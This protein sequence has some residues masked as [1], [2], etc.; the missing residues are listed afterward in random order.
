MPPVVL[1]LSSARVHPSP[2]VFTHLNEEVFL[3]TFRSILFAAICVAVLLAPFASAQTQP[4][5]IITYQGNGQMVCSLCGQGAFYSRFEPIWAKVVDANGNPVPGTTVYWNVQIG[6][7]LLNN[8]VTVT[9]NNGLTSNYYGVYDINGSYGYPLAQSQIIASIGSPATSTATFYE[10]QALSLNDVDLVQAKATTM[11]TSLSGSAGTVVQNGIVGGAASLTGYPV[12]GVELLLIN[13]Q[14]S[15]S[16]TCA[17]MSGNA[18]V[19]DPGTV[20]TQSNGYAVCSPI[21]SGSGSGSFSIILGGVAYSPT[22]QGTVAYWQSSNIPLTVTAPSPGSIV[23]LFGN[24]QSAT[25]GQPLQAPLMATVEDIKGNP[26][27]GETV[28]WSVSP[29]GA[30]TF[31]NPSSVSDSNGSVQNSFTLSNTANGTIT[32]TVAIPNTAIAA[33]FSENAVP[34][35]TVAMIQKLSG[36]QQTAVA[37]QAFTSALVVQATNTNGQPASGFTVNFSVVGPAYISTSAAPVTNSAGQAQVSLIAEATAS[38]AQVYVSAALGSLTPV[39]FQL[40]VNPAGP[41]ITGTSF[42]NAADQ[43]AGSISPCSLATV[44]GPG[45]APNVQGTVVGTPLGPGPTS[46][47]N[48]TISFSVSGSSVLAPIFSVTNNN[49]TQSITFQVPCEVA[50]VAPG[51]VPVTVSVGGGTATVNTAVLAASPGIYSAK[52]ADGV[53]RALLLRADGTFAA[54]STSPTGRP[55][56]PGDT[57]TVFVTGLGPTFPVV[58]TN[59][60]PPRGTTAAAT[61]KVIVGIGSG[62]TAPLVYAQLTSDLVGVYEVQFTIP[63]T[64]GNSDSVPFSIGVIPVGA[65]VAQY[66]NLVYIPVHQ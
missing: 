48:A 16:V 43:K 23:N 52:G 32:I 13:N 44:T 10:T 49:G 63:A 35:V 18:L 41:S 6:N 12:P 14:A 24:N 56:S 34:L 50:Q 42:V 9:D 30:G 46:L 11:P 17:P 60:L 15:P 61:G 27:A 62:G 3:T 64:I 26:I 55:A 4:M 40:T 31:A 2:T 8:A 28:T 57:V 1:H 54:P 51:T 22:W 36:D 47:Q 39:T 29:A 65:N 25:A 38:T 53:T 33:R 5:S 20:M 45:L 21:L 37:G 19:G 59:Q 7:G 58:G 66:T